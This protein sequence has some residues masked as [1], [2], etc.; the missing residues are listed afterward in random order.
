MF[1][2]IAC[3]M[4]DFGNDLIYMYFLDYESFMFTCNSGTGAALSSR[5]DMI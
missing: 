2:Y 1:S 5:F 4:Y 3:N